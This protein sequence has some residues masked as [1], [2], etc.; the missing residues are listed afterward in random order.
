[1]NSSAET[2]ENLDEALQDISEKLLDL[3]QSVTQ[4]QQTN[5][6]QAVFNSFLKA[7]L[8]FDFSTIYK[9]KIYFISKT[10]ADFEI[11]YAASSCELYGGYLVEIDD[12]EELKFVS[13]FVSQTGKDVRYLTG[14][15]DKTMEGYF[16]F[17][18]SKKPMPSFLSLWNKC[19]PN[20]MVR[21][22][23]CTEIV[24]KLNDVTCG[25]PGKYVCQ[26]Q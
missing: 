4:Q 9:G 2:V 15:N 18:H 6:N 10:V 12:E 26:S 1:M 14:L 19:E 20:S 8:P 16:E 24:G 11:A 23:V 22:E 21:V 3:Q 13:D 25:L 17:Y 5:K 7:R